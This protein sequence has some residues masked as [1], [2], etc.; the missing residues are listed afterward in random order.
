[1]PY[2]QHGRRHAAGGTDPI[3][4][5]AQRLPWCIAEANIV[6]DGTAPDY[7]D[8]VTADS[9]VFELKGTSDTILI[10]EPGLF[11]V[12][13]SATLQDPS[14]DA[15]TVLT[16]R[17]EPGSGGT[18]TEIQF[19]AGNGDQAVGNPDGAMNDWNCLQI[20]VVSVTA[21][22]TGLNIAVQ[23]TSNP[24]VSKTGDHVLWIKKIDDA[25]TPGL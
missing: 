18:Y 9:S 4:G 19:N 1:M 2:L 13:S 22:T 24:S 23:W 20:F 5:V 15:S 11:E 21:I 7:F 3:P 14:L 6:T 10:K 25:Y 12:V 8:F 16:L 17:T